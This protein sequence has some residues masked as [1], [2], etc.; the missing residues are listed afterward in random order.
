LETL[1]NRP[2]IGSRQ[3]GVSPRC[4]SWL[5]GPACLSQN[6]GRPDMRKPSSLKLAIVLTTI[7][8]ALSLAAVALGS[9]KIHA[10]GR[11]RLERRPTDVYNPFFFGNILTGVSN[12]LSSPQTRLVL[13]SASGTDEKDLCFNGVFGVRSTTLCYVHY[14]GTDSNTV[15]TVA[16]NAANMVVLFLTTNQPGL[17]VTYIDSYCFNPPPPWQPLENMWSRFRYTYLQ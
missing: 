5:T 1:T 9:R 12:F 3:R 10:A 17:E 11:F 13:S 6:V 4:L 7:A 16:S 14:S 8:V 15:Q 2:T